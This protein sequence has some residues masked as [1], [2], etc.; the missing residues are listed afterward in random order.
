MA[1]DIER[2]AVD[3][4][5]RTRCR[6]V[7]LE[8]GNAGAGRALTRQCGRNLDLSDFDEGRRFG[9]G[10][11]LRGCDLAR[12]GCGRQRDGVAADVEHREAVEHELLDR[13]LLVG[14]E[15]ER[16]AH[17]PLLGVDP[18]LT[19][20]AVLTDLFGEQRR[21]P[22]GECHPLGIAIAEAGVA[23]EHV[24]A[25]AGERL[26]PI[27]LVPIVEDA[28]GVTVRSGCAA[29]DLDVTEAPARVTPHAVDDAP[30]E[31][32]GN[33]VAAEQITRRR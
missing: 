2:Q 21:Q 7:A 10:D 1:V 16:G 9:G 25:S 20:R 19:D 12:R 24:G 31:I 5:E 30:A 14:V 4:V 15:H 11:R 28:V 22:F 32:V 8:R 29:G 17:H 18:G 23:H 6:I 33:V 13:L 26:R 27:G 3:V